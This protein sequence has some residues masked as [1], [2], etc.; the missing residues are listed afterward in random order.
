MDRTIV[1]YASTVDDSGGV[2]HDVRA[3]AREM[4]RGAWEAWF[5]LRPRDGGALVRTPP[6]TTQPDR[7][8]LVRW[9]RGI[10]R[11]YLKDALAH[12]FADIARS[13]AIAPD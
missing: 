7:A 12:A 8:S 1:V 11:D 3:C 2:A 9:A 6:D 13:R 5:E 10:S 4:D